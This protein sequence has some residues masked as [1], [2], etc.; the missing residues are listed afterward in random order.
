MYKERSLILIAY[1]YHIIPISVLDT[2]ISKMLICHTL[3]VRVY[4]LRTHCGKICA[5]ISDLL[6]TNIIVPIVNIWKLIA[7]ANI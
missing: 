4:F 7:Y 2:S 6:S 5:I 1:T 3:L